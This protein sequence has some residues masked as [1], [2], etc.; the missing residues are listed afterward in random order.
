MESFYYLLSFD[1]CFGKGNVSLCVFRGAL[2]GGRVGCVLCLFVTLWLILCHCVLDLHNEAYDSIC[3]SFVGCINWIIVF[4]MTVFFLFFPA[5]SR[6]F[7]GFFACD[8]NG[9]FGTD[10][11]PRRAERLGL[12]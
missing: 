4:N 2:G 3:V 8:R 10:R 1:N 6:G 5:E 11:D 9:V 12:D 7:N